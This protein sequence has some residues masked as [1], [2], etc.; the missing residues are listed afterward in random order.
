MP[1]LGCCRSNRALIPNVASALASASYRNMFSCRDS[2]KNIKSRMRPGAKEDEEEKTGHAWAACFLEYFQFLYCS[3]PPPPS[4][5]DFGGLRRN[6]S[7]LIYCKTLNIIFDREEG[8]KASLDS[9]N[10]VASRI[11][12]AL[13]KF[14]VNTL[15]KGR[16]KSW[17]KRKM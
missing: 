9:I 8:G 5:R 11:Q 4:P 14:V 6:G 7:L 13:C 12:M 3:P 10:V 2:G 15:W 1:V 16:R 17:L